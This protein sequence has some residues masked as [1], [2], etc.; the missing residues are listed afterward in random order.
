MRNQEL[1]F[2]YTMIYKTTLRSH[3]D[4][5]QN[6]ISPKDTKENAMIDDRAE[7]SSVVELVLEQNHSIDIN[8]LNLIKHI[9]NNQKLEAY[10]NLKKLNN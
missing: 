9:T 8:S 5:T 3:L 10:E 2:I 1:D 6:I 7:K 4:K